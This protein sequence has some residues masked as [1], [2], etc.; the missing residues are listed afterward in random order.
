MSPAESI[1][2]IFLPSQFHHWAWRMLSPDVP[3]MVYGFLMEGC[4]ILPRP[5]KTRDV[6]VQ[7][8]LGSRI[9]LR[10]LEEASEQPLTCE[11]FFVDDLRSAQHDL[12]A[13]DLSCGR[14]MSGEKWGE[15]FTASHAG[16]ERFFVYRLRDRYR[17][18]AFRKD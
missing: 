1:P 9:F 5:K 7:T 13:M 16:K 3:S 17:P 10:P 18:P 8:V 12:E 11:L 14:I 4:K 2:A 6:I 15:Y